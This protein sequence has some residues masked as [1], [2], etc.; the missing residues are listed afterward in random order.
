MLVSTIL[1]SIS[2]ILDSFISIFSNIEIIIQSFIALGTVGAV[3]LALFIENIKRWQK[4]VTLEIEKVNKYKEAKVYREINKMDAKIYFILQVKA[5]QS[6]KIANNVRIRINSVVKKKND[7]IESQEYNN[8][9][10]LQWITVDK[11]KIQHSFKDR[12]KFFL[13]SFYRDRE[14]YKFIP[15]I[16]DYNRSYN[17]NCNNDETAIYELEIIADNYHK[18]KKFY[19][20]V[21]YSGDSDRDLNNMINYVDM[22]IVNHNKDF[23]DPVKHFAK[24]NENSN[25]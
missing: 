24:L 5:T 13:G 21:I 10:M 25:I 7:K 14:E 8:E 3:I 4:S 6:S 20:Q 12:K 22:I 1:Y 15:T 18:D 9:L 23:R 19:I 2:I 16:L 17:I 11:E